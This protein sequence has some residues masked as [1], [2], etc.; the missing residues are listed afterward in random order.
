VV[1]DEAVVEE[2]LGQLHGLLRGELQPGRRSGL[3]VHR[4]EG[5]LGGLFG[6]LLLDL[7]GKGVGLSLDSCDEGFGFCLLFELPLGVVGQEGGA[8]LDELDAQDPVGGC[9]EGADLPFPINHQTNRRRLDPTDAEDGLESPAG[10]GGEDVAH[11]PVAHPAPQEGMVEPGV[12]LLKRGRLGQGLLEPFLCD[13]V[14]LHPEALLGDILDFVI[15]MAADSV[16]FSVRVAGQHHRLSG[17]R[18]AEILGKMLFFLMVNEGRFVTLEIDADFGGGKILEVSHRGNGFYLQ[19][20]LDF[21]SL[22]GR[23]DDD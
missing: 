8:V 23:F 4:G 2:P 7:L 19:D 9:G 11:Q 3:Q 12:G 21:F 20:R 22:G 6:L 13:L 14:D 18:L 17:G 5:G 16:P 10:N 1:G 15:D